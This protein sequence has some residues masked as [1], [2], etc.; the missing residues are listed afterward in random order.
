MKKK[1]LATCLAGAFC[2]SAFLGLVGCGDGGKDPVGDPSEP[3]KID[4]TAPAFDQADVTVSLTGGIDKTT[5]SKQISSDLFGL[6]L[7]DINFACYGLDDNLVANGSFANKGAGGKGERWRAEPSSIFKVASTDGIFKNRP[8]FGSINPDYAE[9][10]ATAGS[11]LTNL[12]YGAAP[13]AVTEGVDYVFSAFIK[14]GS[15]SDGITVEVTD[16]TTVYA[17][18]ELSLAPSAEWVKYRATV[19]ATGTSSKDLV[20]KITFNGTGKVLLDCVKFETTDSTLGFKNYLYNAI[21]DMSPA[22]FRFPGGCIIEGKD[23]DSYYDWKKSIGASL[24]AGEATAD[25]VPEFVYQLNDE[26]KISEER[27]YGEQATRDYS[28]D[29]WA[30]NDGNGKSYYQMEYGIGFYEYFM[31]C[32]SLGAKAIPVLNC[33]KACQGQSIGAA[34]NG[35]H[36][37]KIKDFVQDAKDLICFAK[38]SV[39]S[40]DPNE[41]YWAQVRVNMGHPEPFEMDYLGIGNEQWGDYYTRY[42]EEFLKEFAFEDNDL[43]RSVKIIVGNCTLFMHCELPSAN[44]K[45]LAQQAALNY[46]KSGKIGA[47]SDYGVH[48]QHYYMNYTD[49]LANTT[50][51]DG[52]KRPDTDP[53]EYYEVFV[54]EYSAN[55]LTVCSPEPDE[56]TR[57]PYAENSWITALSEA[58]MMTG[59]ERNGD[60]VK[61]AAYA[62]MFGNLI[63]PSDMNINHHWGVN[64]MFFNATD[65]VLTPNYYVQQ[66]FMQNAGDHKLDSSIAFASGSAPK[67]DYKGNSK[68]TGAV[69]TRT[70]DDFFYVASADGETGDLIVKIVNAGGTEMKLNLDVGVAGTELKGTAQI[71]TLQNFKSN[72][73]SS[74]QGDA[75]QPVKRVVNGF[76]G[77]NKIG[78][79]I[80]P[81][82]VTA[83]RIRTK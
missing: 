46:K 66:L 37:N 67:T 82:S 62:P 10:A 4:G 81:Y 54:G 56:N 83:V 29:I 8:A 24:V 14:T 68:L 77:G 39:N 33:G 7:E 58:A 18:K 20:M 21:K 27:T 51:Y 73:V 30:L 26:G 70:L 35:R 12:G 53:N 40:S 42:Y 63:R 72:A 45:G 1:V 79:T 22:F 47:V 49:F 13:I 17:K 32:D 5:A 28:T 55:T 50:M 16:G 38:G 52:Y 36:G 59:Y 9:I 44:R 75:V 57:F 64:M 3:E 2:A 61:L 41:K 43:Y 74:L 25:T 78:V 80:D 11:S 19:T 48:D 71:T 31:L 65:V 60:I 15:Y 34:L 6:F 23:D 69:V 76:T